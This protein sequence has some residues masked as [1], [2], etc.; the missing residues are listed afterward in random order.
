MRF[1]FQQSSTKTLK[2]LANEVDQFGHNPPSYTHTHTHTHMVLA[3]EI[4]STN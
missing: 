3:L 1:L 2:H 4:V